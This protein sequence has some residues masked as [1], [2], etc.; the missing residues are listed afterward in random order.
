M[1]LFEELGTFEYGDNRRK[2][3]NLEIGKL[4]G[5]PETAVKYFVSMESKA[6]PSEAHKARLKKYLHYA[7][8]DTY[9][10]VEFRAYDVK[11]NRATEKY[12]PRSARVIRK[13]FPNKRWLD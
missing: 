3:I 10:E 7:H 8:S 5:Y 6:R 11:V 12:A 9:Q 2:E 4:L 1:E 13:K